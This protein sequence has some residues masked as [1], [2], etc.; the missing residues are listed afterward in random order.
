[1]K[2]F[3]NGTEE[4]YAM[5]KTSLEDH[6]CHVYHCIYPR[7]FSKSNGRIGF[8]REEASYALFIDKGITCSRKKMPSLVREWLN[9]G[10]LRFLDFTDMKEFLRSLKIL[11]E[12][13]R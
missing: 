2:E 1:M 5:L 13:L 7:C 6:Q 4:Q 9:S 3:V 8:E 10:T 11:Y 12:S